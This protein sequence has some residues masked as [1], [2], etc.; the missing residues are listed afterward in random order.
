MPTIIENQKQY[1]T[2]LLFLVWSTRC[3]GKYECH[4]FR[5]YSIDLDL[6][7]DANAFDFVFRNV[8]GGYLALFSR[9]DKIQIY[10]NDEGLLSGT[11]DSVKYSYT[12]DGE[13]IIRVTGRDLVA[14][15]ID[16]DALPTTLQNIQ[17][18]SYIAEKCSE[19]GIPSTQ[20]DQ[21][22]LIEERIIGVGETEISIINDMAKSDNFKHWLDFETFHVGRW[23]DDTTPSLLFTCGVPSDKAGIPII[24]LDLEEDGSEVYSESIVYGS[25]SDG[26]DKVLGRYKNDYMVNNGIKR[27]KTFSN[28][29]NDDSDK[30]K[31]NA[32]DD[33][34]YGF[35]NH[36]VLILTV[37]TPSSGIIKPNTTCHV[38]DWITRTN[39]TFFIKSVNYSKDIQN[40]SLCKI[41]AVPTK[42]CNDAMYGAQG[43]LGGGITGRGSWTKEELMSNKKG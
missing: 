23:N 33:V 22:S 38:I 16:N 20:L 25:T 5:E 35:D 2:N 42:Q 29:N 18:N 1:D 17:P 7:T 26:S 10:L 40:G 36:N 41:T 14:A 19:Y 37:R 9:F 30:Y 24:T 21:M 11:V 12:S 6:D 43:S 32:E 34:R 13:P 4:R 28:T 15:L 3:G 31:S 27:R 8:E 39:A